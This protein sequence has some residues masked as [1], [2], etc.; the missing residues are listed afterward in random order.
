[1][2]ITCYETF[3]ALAK[4]QAENSPFEIDIP[5]REFY[6]RISSTYEGA[7]GPEQTAAILKAYGQKDKFLEMSPELLDHIVQQ[8]KRKIGDGPVYRNGAIE[9]VATIAVIN[10]V[11]DEQKF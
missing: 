7:V 8:T 11:L 10:S 6:C 4:R 1:M 9:G 5:S 2:R 3:H